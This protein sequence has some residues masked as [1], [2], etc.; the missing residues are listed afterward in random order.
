[1]TNSSEKKIT[2]KDL[3]VVKNY[4]GSMTLTKTNEAKEKLSG[5]TFIIERQLPQNK[6][7]QI[8][9]ERTTNKEGIVIF[10]DLEPE[11][12]ALSKSRLQPAMLK[13]LSQLNLR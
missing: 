12:I 3:G 4:R 5:A 8:D 2:P 7:E 1:M 13:I 10:S 6:W 11:F 9:K